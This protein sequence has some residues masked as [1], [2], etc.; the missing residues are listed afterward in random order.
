MNI[1]KQILP[2]IAFFTLG[3]FSFNTVEK[4]FLPTKLQITVIDRLGNLVSGATVKI[5]TTE[6]DYRNNEAPVAAAVS[7]EKGRVVF[8]DLNPVS[9]FIDAQKEDKNNN[10][11]GVKTAALEEGKKNKVNTV[12]E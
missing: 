4:D 7:D 6:D 8:K 9:Y 11:E 1:T 2:I 10:G 5:Y 12:I 3:L